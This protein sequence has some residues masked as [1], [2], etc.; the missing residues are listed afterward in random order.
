MDEPHIWILLNLIWSE[1]LRKER[2]K[3]CYTPT[4]TKAY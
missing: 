3:Y 4:H 2:R 1:S